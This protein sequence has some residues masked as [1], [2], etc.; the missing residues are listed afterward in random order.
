[1]TNRLPLLLAAV[2]M[3]ATSRQAVSLR[4]STNTRCS[5]HGDSCCSLCSEFFCGF[6]HGCSGNETDRTDM[7]FD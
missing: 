2:K 7:G 1:M 5:N 6:L 4:N 3:A